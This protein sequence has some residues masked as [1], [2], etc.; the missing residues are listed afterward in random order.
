MKDIPIRARVQGFLEGIYF[1]KQTNDY[2]PI[3]VGSNACIRR[4][5]FANVGTAI[6][7]I[8]DPSEDVIIDDC[9]FNTVTNAYYADAVTLRRWKFKTNK[10]TSVTTVYNFSGATVED[11]VYVYDGVQ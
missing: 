11:M 7:A 9:V 1:D 8:T 2:L 10:Y 6:K 5:H 3:A 4:C